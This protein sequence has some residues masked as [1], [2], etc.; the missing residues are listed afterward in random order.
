M[1]KIKNYLNK[2]ITRGD[3][4]K[5]SMWSLAI[6]AAMWGGLYV[7]SLYSDRKTYR[8]MWLES[9]GNI[10]QENDLNDPKDES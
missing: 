8:E 5:E 6:S 7:Y 4:L 2:P 10:E 3:I 9:I 1:G